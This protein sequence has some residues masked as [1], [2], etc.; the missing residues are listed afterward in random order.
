MVVEW[1]GDGFIINIPRFESIGHTRG[2][3][4][5]TNITISN[6]QSSKF[7]IMVNSKQ[8]NNSG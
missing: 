3:S 7:A 2:F 5:H 6:F 1:L 4:F 8:I